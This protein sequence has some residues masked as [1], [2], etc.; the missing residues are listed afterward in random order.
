MRKLDR[1]AVNDDELLATLSRSKGK[2]AVAVSVRQADVL[3]RYTT[4]R[5]CH[6]DPWHVGVD[7]S[8]G[9]V[10][11]SL[12]GL[13]KKPP[14]ALGF[15]ASLR[16]SLEG[17]CPICG[18]EGL[19]TLDHYLPKDDYS[20]YSVFS[21]N[22]IPA[23]NRCNNAK[24]NL[25]KGDSIWERPVHPYFDDFASRRLMTIRAEPDWSAPRLTPIPYDVEGDERTV[26]QW[27]I[28][29]VI[30]PSGLDAY[31]TNLWGR[32]INK[33]QTYLGNHGTRQAVR[34][35]LGRLVDIEVQTVCSY[36]GWRSCFYHGLM[37][38]DAAVDHLATLL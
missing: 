3:K 10:R 15:I 18:R 35:A 16:H 33:P 22:L 21:L 13:F 27:H 19:G 36:N 7:T 9:H 30:R 34:E 32:L 26:V 37:M 2:N 12:H 17:A 8:Y 14:K 28:E 1:P 24:N 5:D 31:L 38:D 11:T 23:C 6:G 4:Y 29:N 25:V 20:E